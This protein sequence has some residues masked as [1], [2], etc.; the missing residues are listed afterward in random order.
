MALGNSR[1]GIERLL[2]RET[3]LMQLA[4]LAQRE[5]DDRVRRREPLAR[6]PT[7]EG[8]LRQG[9]DGSARRGVVQTKPPRFPET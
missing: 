9:F 8:P 6:Q 7:A 2:A 1:A 3:E 4:Q 5:R